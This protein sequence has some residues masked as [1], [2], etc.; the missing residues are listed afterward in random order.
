[1]DLFDLDVAA[2]T[3]L[4]SSKH[5]CFNEHCGEHGPMVLCWI[6]GV[7]GGGGHCFRL[8]PLILTLEGWELIAG[9]WQFMAHTQELLVISYC[10]LL[11]NFLHNI[12]TLTGRNRSYF[13]LL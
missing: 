1:M 9:A 6:T 2:I 13:N 7:G 10:I 5:T 11:C 12:L 8:S 3:K 4:S